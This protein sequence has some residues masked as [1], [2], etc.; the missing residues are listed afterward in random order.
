MSK[1]KT[2]HDILFA[3]YGREFTDATKLEDLGDSLDLLNVLVEIEESLGVEIPPG[4][5]PRLETVGELIAA[6]EVS[7]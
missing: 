6:L 2:V 7:N 5:L 4:K 3:E 1:N